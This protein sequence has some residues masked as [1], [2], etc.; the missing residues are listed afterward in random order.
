MPNRVASH[1]FG[2]A[3]VE[4]AWRDEMKLAIALLGLVAHIFVFS[5]FRVGEFPS[6]PEVIK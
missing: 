4:S 3:S 6:I 1:G 5:E 2:R